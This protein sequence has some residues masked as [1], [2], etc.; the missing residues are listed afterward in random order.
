M[1]AETGS[2][3]DTTGREFDKMFGSTAGEILRGQ[4]QSRKTNRPLPLS[5]KTG[6]F[7]LTGYNF[8]VNGIGAVEEEMKG[9]YLLSYFPPTNTFKQ[10]KQV[11][12]HKLKIKVKRPGA[13][14]RTRDGFFGA[15][16]SLTA[17]DKD[18]NPLM[19]AMFSPFRYN[20]LNLNLASGYIDNPPEGYLL[21]AWLHLDGRQVGF[22]NDEDG[23]HSVSLEAVA[24]TSDIDSLIQDSGN[25]RIGFRVNDREIQWIRENGIAFSISIPA[26]KPG[27]YFV[28]AA[29][30]DQ[31]SGAIGSA[32]QFVE[33]PDLAKEGLS[34]SSIFVADRDED[35]SWIQSGVIEDSRGQTGLSKQIARRSQAFRRYLPG[36][37][38]D[39]MAVIYNAK[40]KEGLKPDLESQFVL[41]KNGNEIFRSKPEAVSIGGV[42]DFKRI[43]IK[44]RLKL[45]KTMQPGDYVLQL[46]VRDK[47]ANEKQSLVAQILDFE[48]VSKVTGAA[49]SQTPSQ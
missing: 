17:P 12:H 35:S 9:Y 38:F 29:V 49:I 25:A 20:G 18:R 31:A 44:K 13:E 41:F 16:G 5:Q 39:Y 37:S 45:E 11:T 21:K 33:I 14:V 40:T 32:Y 42:K 7:F 30:K 26:K 2:F 28:R 24:V 43:A 27:S 8:F 6:G 3:G 48:I 15:P 4:V 19:D 46:Q 34:L 1:D 10:A 22:I 47:Q 23:G 36:E